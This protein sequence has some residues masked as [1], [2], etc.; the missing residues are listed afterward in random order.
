[1]SDSTP[2]VFVSA[3]SKDLGEVRAAISA[4]LVTMG[5]LPVEQTT[6]APDYRTVADMLRGKIAGCHA[7]I[8]V[9][10]R[11]YGAEPDPARLPSGAVRRSYTQME[12]YL[13][14]ELKKKVFT[15]ICG[16]DFPYSDQ[17]IAPEAPE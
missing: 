4:M 13:A 3:T 17:Q 15:F 9:V 16:E 12:Y 10:G 11:R 14:R 5:C 2:K 8:H 1:M 7:V 6:F